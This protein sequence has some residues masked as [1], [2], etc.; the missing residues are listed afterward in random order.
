MTDAEIK[1]LRQRMK[2]LNLNRDE[3]NTVTVNTTV[4]KDG[5]GKTG[6]YMYRQAEIE[7]LHSFSEAD[8]IR[9]G[10]Y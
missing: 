7:K 1:E 2:D 4:R 6:D 9:F 10:S 3:P 8:L 5:L